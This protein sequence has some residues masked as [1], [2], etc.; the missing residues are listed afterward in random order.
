MLFLGDFLRSVISPSGFWDMM[1]LASYAHWPLPFSH[2]QIRRFPV[3][4][5]ETLHPGHLPAES[6]QMLKYKRNLKHAVLSLLTVVWP[7]LGLS[8]ARTTYFRCC[9]FLRGGECSPV[10]DR[11][12]KRESYISYNRIMSIWWWTRVG[13]RQAGA[14]FVDS[15]VTW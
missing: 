7:Y 5:F 6:L 11:R 10:P 14:E 1:R 13:G 2:C 4:K 12:R 8:G 15:S 3:L 9:C